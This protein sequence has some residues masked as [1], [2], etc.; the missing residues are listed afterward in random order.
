MYLDRFRPSDLDLLKDAAAFKEAIDLMLE[1]YAER[2]A[3]DVPQ[4][5]LH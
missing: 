5:N 4:K 3:L 1:P 2:L